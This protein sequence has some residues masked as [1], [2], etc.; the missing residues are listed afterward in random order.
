MISP[1]QADLVPKDNLEQWLKHLRT[2][3]PTIAFKASTQTGQS[4]LGQSNL[5]VKQSTD[6]QMQTSK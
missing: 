1:L 4:K 2:Q 6:T 3:L 5:T